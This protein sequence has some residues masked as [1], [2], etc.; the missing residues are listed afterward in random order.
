MFTPVMTY[1]YMCTCIQATMVR[2][3]P[4]STWVFPDGRNRT[5]DDKIRYRWVRMLLLTY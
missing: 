2:G 1:V 4:Y 5:K 3:F